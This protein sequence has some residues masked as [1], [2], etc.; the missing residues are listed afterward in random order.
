MIEVV[1]GLIEDNEGRVLACLRP[2]GKHL[3]GKWEFPGGKIDPGETPEAALIRELQEELGVDI[4]I[5][6]SLSPVEWDYSGR[7]IR[8][9]PFRCMIISG[10]PTPLEHADIRWIEAAHLGE[11]DWA[12]ADGPILAEWLEMTR[13]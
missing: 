1:C 10:T 12:E 5:E 11:L 13:R 4:R 2:E 9:I 3:G 7:A 8:L 6:A